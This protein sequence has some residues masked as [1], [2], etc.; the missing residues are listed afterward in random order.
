MAKIIRTWT[1]LNIAERIEFGQ[2]VVDSLANNPVLPATDAD[3]IAFSAAQTALRTADDAV[4]DL[5]EALRTA[6]L[7]RTAM[8]DDFLDKVE[9]LAKA[10]DAAAKGDAAKISSTGFEPSEGGAAQAPQSMTQVINFSV[11]AGDLDG[12][13]DYQHDRVRRARTYEPQTTTNPNDAASWA[14]HPYT[15]RSSNTLKDLPSG[16]RQWVRVRAL[17]S[18]GPGPWSDPAMKVVP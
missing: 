4:S 15:T 7:D 18:L 2:T 14:S 17:G 11:T 16:T 10:V 5:E 6:R 8:I 1:K 13:L 12:E 3:Y 9:Q